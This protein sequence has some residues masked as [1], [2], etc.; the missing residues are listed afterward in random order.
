MYSPSYIEEKIPATPANRQ[1]CVLHGDNSAGQ[2]YEPYP[3]YPP[4]SRNTAY[5]VES[6]TRRAIK[7]PTHRIQ[8]RAK[9]KHFPALSAYEPCKGKVYS[10]YVEL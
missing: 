4:N 8:N 6:H 2:L 3:P 7:S 1:K 9:Y 5:D 10:I